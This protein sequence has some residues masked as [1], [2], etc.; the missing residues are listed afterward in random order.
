MLPGVR[1]I[2]LL[3]LLAF[4]CTTVR[5]AA[6]PGTE[7][8]DAPGSIAPPIVELWIESSEQVSQ[9]ESDHAAEAAQQA[10]SQ[11][12]SEVQVSATAL[13]AAD[14]VL[15]VRERGVAL[16]DARTHQQTWAKI[17]IVAV[18]AAAIIAVAVASRTGGG[19]GHFTRATVPRASGGGMV[20]PIPR[21]VV[22]IPARGP[23][24]YPRAAP[25]PVFVSFNFFIPLH[26]LVVAPVPEGDGPPFPPDA[27]IPMIEAAPPPPGEEPQ[28]LASNDGPPP[29]PAEEAPA[30]LELPELLPPAGFDVDSRDFFD[31]TRI[32]LQLDLLDRATGELLWSKPVASS[33]NPCDP[34]DVGELLAQALDGQSWA[35][36]ALH[37]E[38]P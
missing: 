3:T 10:I 22:P 12:V 33:G 4:G 23:R 21:N 6:L 26:P 18:V 15:F 7:A 20:R 11:A 37:A 5:V 25:L 14:A 29:P 1:R 8:V 24:L 17:G 38:R 13:G 35:R 9:A 30:P 28:Q 32:G 34:H 27:P 2:A 16:T 36:P 19:R 31:G